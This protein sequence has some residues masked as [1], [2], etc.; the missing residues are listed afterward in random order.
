VVVQRTFAVNRTNP[1]TG[2]ERVRV[3]PGL[4]EFE[5]GAEYAVAPIRE[6]SHPEPPLRIERD[7]EEIAERAWA[8]AS[9]TDGSK[10]PPLPVE[11]SDF[12]MLL[13]RDEERSVRCCFEDQSTAED[14]GAISVDTAQAQFF[15]KRPLRD[16]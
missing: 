1:G 8:A 4:L 12:R 9:T 2:A 11:D 16:R 3:R 10:M 5:V 13:I 14:I 15:N 6:V 7:L